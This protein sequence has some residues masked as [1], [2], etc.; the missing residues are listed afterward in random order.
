MQFV[1]WCQFVFRI[2]D[3]L[4]AKETDKWVNLKKS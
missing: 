1:F 2:F 3:I 4:S